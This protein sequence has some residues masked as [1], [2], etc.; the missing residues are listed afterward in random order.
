MKADVSARLL[1][2]PF[3]AQ[4]ALRYRRDGAKYVLYSVGPDGRDD[5]GK[6][7]YD[8]TKPVSSDG[9]ERPRYFVEQNS[10]GDIVAGISQ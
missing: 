10:V 6:P 3:A 9:S 4:G 7:I 8:K 2:D 5:G 1:T